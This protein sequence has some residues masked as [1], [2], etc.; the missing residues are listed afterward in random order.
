[1]YYTSFYNK[2]NIHTQKRSF[3]ISSSLFFLLAFLMLQGC[4]SNNENESYENTYEV[5]FTPD[6]KGSNTQVELTVLPVKN[7]SNLFVLAQSNPVSSLTNA[8]LLAALDA[9]SSVKKIENNSDPNSKL[10]IHPSGKIISTINPNVPADLYAFA[11]NSTYPLGDS[12]IV[13][14][15]KASL[16]FTSPSLG[17]SHAPIYSSYLSLGVNKKYKSEESL[18]FEQI[19][20]NVRVSIEGGVSAGG[21][22]KAVSIV[23]V[24]TYGIYYPSTKT[25]QLKRNYGNISIDDLNIVTPQA[26]YTEL[27]S[28]GASF[29]VIPQELPDNATLRIT[30]ADNS[31]LEVSLSGQH[32]LPNSS[33]IYTLSNSPTD[34]F[35]YVLT[36]QDS[37]VLFN[38]SQAPIS[39]VSYKQ[40][41]SG[42]A[43]V[44]EPVSW[45]IVGY[46]NNND[47]IFSLEEKPQWLSSISLLSGAG[48]VSGEQT[49]ATLQI[50]TTDRSLERN[51][52]LKT[53]YKGSST[54]PFDLSLHSVSGQATT[55]NSANSYIISSPG[56]YKIP[57]VYG[58]AVKNGVNN[59]SAY[60]SSISGNDYILTKFLDH[61]NTPI[62]SPYINV[63]NYNEVSSASIVWSDAAGIVQN[64]SVEGTGEETYVLFEVPEGSIKEGN[65]VVGIKDKNDQ[66]MWSWHLWIAPSSVADAIEVS[67]KQ[68]S[69]MTFMSE[70]LGTK[71]LQWSASAYTTDRSVKVKVRQKE[72]EEYTTFTITQKAGSLKKR[73]AT[74]YQWGRKDALPSSQT[75]SE[76]TFEFLDGSEAAHTI[77]FAINN[78]NKMIGESIYD[79]SRS[80]VSTAWYNL[81]NMSQTNS[82]AENT[83]S[84]IKT[85]YDP[86]PVGYMLPPVN[87]FQF[88]ESI[89]NQNS[90][91]VLQESGYTFTSSESSSSLQIPFIPYR[92]Y[93]GKITQ[94]FGVFWSSSQNLRESSKVLY[95]S[96]TRLSINDYPH[97]Y[98]VG[99]LPVKE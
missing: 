63:Q 54:T 11:T 27:S 59:T 8:E 76:G 22:I 69:S 99:V 78:P 84:R 55:R 93:Q 1:M 64:I 21:T 82:N 88:L 53:G 33:V 34:A 13:A 12:V 3:L 5:T 98:A 30:L 96:P 92:D 91:Q 16:H 85:V 95:I 71:Y 75:V 26:R 28:N 62:V 65:A 87:Y 47:D 56:F 37:E 42:D 67:N 72:G 94:G 83:S 81:W 80:W 31:S 43:L 39:I 25:W 45:E 36:C 18:P 52:A 68:G 4:S 32:W 23:D 61:K 41:V 97:P 44:Q 29:W 35:K 19:L 50:E 86:S 90:D 73:E 66:F 57:A 38:Q 2:K 14:N 74:L 60:E 20:T 17:K 51:N 24:D 58:N 79:A 70:P 46:D 6:L 15:D 49:T 9:N 48:S 89:Y 77:G 10:Y 40:K 7:S